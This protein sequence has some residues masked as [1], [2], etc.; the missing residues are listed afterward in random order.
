MTK[1]STYTKDYKKRV[2]SRLQAANSEAVSADTAET[3]IPKSTL[4]TWINKARKQGKVIPNNE[5][6]PN[7]KWSKD[8]KIR[9]VM[10]TYAIN[11]EELSSYCRKHGL[12][13]ETINQWRELVEDAF[14]PPT[15]SPELQEANKKNSKLEKELRYKDKALAEAA[16]LLVLRKKTPHLK[17]PV[18]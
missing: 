17:F 4:Y 11:E 5:A 13:K 2:M 12:Y 6:N 16:A 1:K 18:M 9:I 15:K 8:N 7:I 3:G 14:D 10:E